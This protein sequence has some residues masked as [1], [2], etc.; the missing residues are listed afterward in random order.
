[1]RLI[2][3]RPVSIVYRTFL[4]V[5][6]DPDADYRAVGLDL[7]HI[8]SGDPDAAYPVVSRRRI[9]CCRRGACDDCASSCHDG[10]GEACRRGDGVIDEPA[11]KSSDDTADE[12]ATAVAPSA[13]VMVV[14]A[15]VA[16]RRG[17]EP[18]TA[19]MSALM[20]PW[21]RSA[22]VSTRSAVGPCEG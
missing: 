9:D 3:G 5:A 1:V 20:H 7:V 12:T 13:V 4:V 22:A 6:G 8:A 19:E 21:R 18:A 14:P 15:V 11:D 16:R 2:Q 17:S 10:V